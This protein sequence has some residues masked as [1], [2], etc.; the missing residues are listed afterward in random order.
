MIF[1]CV[2]TVRLGFL[3][4]TFL[5]F[6]PRYNLDLICWPRPRSR[7]RICSNRDLR[8]AIHACAWEAESGAGYVA[9][10]ECKVARSRN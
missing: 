9:S 3:L 1:V 5:D 6:H 8:V 2:E 4:V 10:R 7:V